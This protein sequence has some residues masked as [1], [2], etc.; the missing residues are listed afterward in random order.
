MKDPSFKLYTERF[1]L[2]T[3]Q[4]RKKDNL[5]PEKITPA[6]FFA[7]RILWDEAIASAA[8]RHLE[9]K[10]GDLVVV[11]TAADHVKFGL[12]APFRLQRLLKSLGINVP[13]GRG[14]FPF[15]YK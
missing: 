8:A 12:G 6:K 10:P 4:K 1:V 7:S 13:S 2:P 9:D 3:F 14:E 11:L 5:L 15:M